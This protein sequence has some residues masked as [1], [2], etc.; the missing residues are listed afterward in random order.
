MSKRDVYIEKMKHQLDELNV[1]INELEDKALEVKEE[2][3]AKF[4][5]EIDSLKLQWQV[6]TDKFA[7]LKASGEDSWDAMVDE[8]EKVREAFVHSF[9]YFK[10]Q[11]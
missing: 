9:R 6:A 3:R 11:L 5:E 2:A 10:S 1:E 8:M 7:A 4:K